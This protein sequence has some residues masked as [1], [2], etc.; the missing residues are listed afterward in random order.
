[1]TKPEDL[2]QRIRYHSDLY[3]NA[4]P[5]ISDKEFDEL[6]DTLRS[7]A[8]DSTVLKEIGAKS[9]SVWPKVEHKR[10]MGSLHKLN[11]KLE[12]ETW[13]EK[14]AGG[15]KTGIFWSEKLDGSSVSL[16]YKDGKFVQ[17]VTRGDG[18]VGDDITPNVMRMNGVPK[19]IDKIA[20]EMFV[21]AE[22]IMPK[23]T[24][25][26]KYAS[27]KAN[28]RNAAAGITRRLDGVGCED[29]HVVTFDVESNYQVPE[30]YAKL[31]WLLTMGFLCPEFGVEYSYTQL[32]KWIEMYEK[33]LR[34]KCEYEI[35]G[36]VLRSNSTALIR[37]MGESSDRP[38]ACRAFKFA[39][40]GA[41]TTLKSVTWQTGRTGVV[42]PVGE[43]EPVNV[44]GVVISRVML[45]NI[46]MI[47][48][49]K[50]GVGSQVELVR[51]NDVIPMVTGARTAGERIL[52]PEKC[53]SCGSKTSFDEVRVFCTNTVDCPAQRSHLLSHFL[54]VLD[55]KGI[56]DAII[57]GLVE[58]GVVEPAELFKVDPETWVRITGSEKVADKVFRELNTK[59][60]KGLTLPKFI[61]A[62][63][64]AGIGEHAV[65]LAMGAG[66]DTVEKLKLA[67]EEDLLKIS[68]I[69]EH[70]AKGLVEGLR[71]KYEWIDA[72]QRR[73]KIE[74]PLRVTAMGDK[75]TGW[76][77]CFTGF[78][79]PELEAKILEQG[80]NI[81]SSWNKKV[82][83]LVAKDASGNSSKLNKARESGA[84]VLSRADLESLL[85]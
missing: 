9:V 75:C 18:R 76:L 48:K 40:L 38:R 19:T 27:S 23:K 7:I 63:G 1:M 49:L 71:T 8:P 79:S 13:A 67:S 44:G 6:V 72:I 30:E 33:D 73:V 4:E 21:R 29:L 26:E 32:H 3:Y 24:F 42:T 55:V 41:V 46:T 39:P 35:D 56:G 28:P 81:A 2:E 85:R 61:D 25:V 60:K 82:T 43:L 10:A 80:G 77:V 53:P 5:I 69:G 14:Y 74:E 37:E 66:Y 51:A 70:I 64:I 68:G 12:I 16:Y 20:G 54:S 15:T 57:D 58:V 59:A 84:M 65:E 47:E 62:L 22:I 11:D 17:A 50:I 34:S 31:K 36:L 52:M 83:H 45:N 78:R